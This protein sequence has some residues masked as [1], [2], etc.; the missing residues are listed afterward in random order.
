EGP[1]SR[2]APGAFLREG[3][4]SAL[5]LLVAHGADGVAVDVHQAR[6]AA[7]LAQSCRGLF[8]QAGLLERLGAGIV[9][10]VDGDYQCA[11]AQHVSSVWSVERLTMKVDRRLS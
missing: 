4:T 10:A 5:E 11:S 3:S 7:A 6:R 8:E 2:S 9:L 1:R